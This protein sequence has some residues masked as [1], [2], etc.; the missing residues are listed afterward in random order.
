MEFIVFSSS[1]GTTFQATIDA[2][3]AGTLQARCLG[4]ITDGPERGCVAKAKAAGLPVCVVEKTPDETREAYDAK[5][6]AAVKSL[7]EHN[8]ALLA[9]MGWMHILS[10]K[11]VNAFPGRI[12]NVH[13]ALLPKYGG[14]GMYG[15][16]VHTAVLAAKEAESGITIHFVDEGVDT[17]KIIVQK[18]CSINADDTVESLR[19]RVQVLEREWYPKTLQ[20]L[21]EEQL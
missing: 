19:E 13:P 5:V 7:D 18:K 20:K 9:L 17:G 15:D 2:M 4:L 1:R 10:A 8:S 16:H 21:H 14:K 6:T 3:S 12:V 11:F